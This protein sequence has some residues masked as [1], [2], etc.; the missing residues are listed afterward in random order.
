M[1]VGLQNNF[2]DF[3]L[4]QN[5]P[6]NSNSVPAAHLYYLKDV[7]PDMSQRSREFKGKILSTFKLLV[8]RMRFWK[9]T[10]VVGQHGL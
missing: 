2:S 10:A 4:Y 5:Q 1:S 9:Q 3:E 7:P 8:K 6:E